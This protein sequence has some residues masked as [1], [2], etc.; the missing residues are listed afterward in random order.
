M[1]VF[2][3]R[4]LPRDQLTDRRGHQSGNNKGTASRLGHEHYG[5]D[6]CPVAGTQ[7]GSQSECR[8]EAWAVGVE[9]LSGELSQDHS[10]DGQGDEQ[11]SHASGGQ[12]D[13]GGGDPEPE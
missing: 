5:R 10:L 13:D 8:V 2:G 1:L 3:D 9:Q 11:T 7:E 4:R 12:G 6:G